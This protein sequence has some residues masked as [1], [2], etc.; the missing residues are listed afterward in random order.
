MKRFV[1]LAL[2]FAPLL[3]A[4]KAVAAPP[5]SRAG[6]Q[7]EAPQQ[8]AWSK[9]KSGVLRVL[10]GADDDAAAS[11]ANSQQSVRRDAQVRPA[12]ANQPVPPQAAPPAATRKSPRRGLFARKGPPGRTVSEYMA[13][14]KP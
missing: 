10:P 9:L 5:Q 8:S 3:L 11:L 2:S 4:D 7:S 12:N 14:E 6:I 1:C 13:Q